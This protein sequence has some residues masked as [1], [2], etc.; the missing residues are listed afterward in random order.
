MNNRVLPILAGCVVVATVWRAAAAD[1]DDLS[2]TVPIYLEDSPAAQE[3]VDRAYHLRD[4][5]RLADAAAVMQQVIEQFPQKLM[6]VGGPRHED[7]ARWVRRVI[8]QDR[9]WLEA[10]RQTYEAEASRQL[11]MARAGGPNEAQ[12][13]ELSHRY[14]L[15][16]AGLEATLD[17]AGL[18]LERGAVEEATGLLHEAGEHPDVAEAGP[19]YAQLK[20]ASAVKRG[21][22]AAA[23][24]AAR[25]LE[26]SGDQPWT[27]VPWP[28]DAAV[29]PS[30]AAT[31]L[32]PETFA[33]PLWEVGLPESPTHDNVL[34]LRR[35]PRVSGQ[36]V[37]IN[38]GMSVLALDRASGRVLWTSEDVRG[39]LQQAQLG[40]FW[41]A[42]R[43]LPDERGVAV[44]GEHV[45]AVLG[46]DLQ[47]L[48]RR[49][50]WPSAAVLASVSAADGRVL[51]KAQPAE[52]DPTLDSAV[53]HGTPLLDSRRAYVLM[54][55]SQ[56]SGFHDAFV[57]AVDVATGKLAWRRHL[58]SAASG[59]R[60]AVR[61]LGS[62]LLEDG[63]LYITD[64]LGVVTCID[65]RTGAIVWSCLL[66]D[67][68]AA[69]GIALAW[70]RTAEQ[71]AS[72]PP[73]LVEAGLVVPA[74]TS[75]APTL[76]LDP[77]TGEVRRELTDEPWTSGGMLSEAGGD[78][79][80]SDRSVSCFD[81][82]TLAL[83][84]VHEAD[85]PPVTRPLA[86]GT[87]IIV[88]RRNR[89]VTLD[90]RTGRLLAD[91]RSPAATGLTVADEQV[92]L[93]T[94]SAVA[95]Y[96]PWDRAYARLTAAMR[97][98]P[99]DPAPGL[100]LAHVA[101]S[102]QR[103][104]A[105]I[106]GIDHAVATL[107]SRAAKAA[108]RPADTGG[109]FAQLLAFADGREVDDPL[110]R[111][112]VFNRL[113]AAAGTATEE[114]A[115]RMALAAFE[116]QTGQVAAAVDQYQS[117]LADDTL[118][119]QLHRDGGTVRQAWMQARHALTALV[120]EHGPQI[121]ER[122]EAAAALQFQQVMTA[123]GGDPA[124][125]QE[126]ARHYPLASV[127]A[128]ALWEAGRGLSEAGQLDDAIAVLR[129]AYR[130]APTPEAAARVVGG[131]AQ[132]AM[133]LDR[134]Q[135][136]RRWL[137][138]FSRMHPGIEPVFDGRAMSADAWLAS[139]AASPAASADAP[140]LQLPLR[141]ASFVPGRVLVGPD[142]AAG[143]GTDDFVVTQRGQTIQRHDGRDL[144][145]T[146]SAPLASDAGYEL[147]WADQ[148]Q[149]VV[150]SS[151]QSSLVALAA[152]SGTRLRDDLDTQSLLD[153]VDDGAVP[154]QEPSAQEGM[155][156]EM[157]DQPVFVRQGGVLRVMHPGD[158]ATTGPPR[159]AAGNEWYLVFADR[160]GRVAC[161]DRREGQVLWR[162]STSMQQI[163]GLR[164]RDDVLVVT[165]ITEPGTDAQGGLVAVLDAA[166]GEP[167]FT[168][169][170]LR[171]PLLMAEIDETRLLLATA[172]EVSAYHLSDGMVAWRTPV[173]GGGISSHGWILGDSL[174]LR[175]GGQTAG[176]LFIH[177]ATGQLQHRMP[178]GVIGSGEPLRVHTVSGL[179]YLI[180]PSLVGCVD[181]HGQLLWRDA[182]VPEGGR[183]EAA[184]V[185][186]GHVI[187]VARLGQ[188][189]A[190]EPG[191]RLQIRIGGAAGEVMVER[192]QADLARMVQDAQPDERADTPA[193]Y[194]VHVFD[195][196][197]GR[198][199]AHYTLGPIAALDPAAARLI[200]GCLVIAAGDRSL[201]IHGSE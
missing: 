3:L 11:A 189:G 57:A 97:D 53:F 153:S 173:E 77:S 176:L 139:V 180:A 68:V 85:D 40:R 9:A 73:V 197:G 38:S 146:W 41:H 88:P 140:A 138:M 168:P 120:A 54:R 198:M 6:K 87:S 66:A 185:T 110:W 12:L 37:L 67:A 170:E 134:P 116:A 69:D 50:L 155:L 175:E 193:S 28:G 108:D 200:D 129:R 152:D 135:V 36:T 14:L 33:A 72:D 84:W 151:A 158:A 95:S 63:R 43:L 27:A 89:L 186:A 79:L 46:P 16:R 25:A 148:E 141:E 34:L 59:H 119:R 61:P 45:V 105:M 18:A 159:M 137:A 10:Y 93:T 90:Q 150:W 91:L 17:L 35:V 26:Q 113:G 99:N 48:N 76:V 199:V 2:Q 163:T 1:P 122:Y 111:R 29:P 161:M 82:R 62:M 75:G 106:E 42:Q 171:E 124:R 184:W 65:V 192:L 83:R 123:Q 142:H 51:W 115:L 44:W 92:I 121:Y 143:V 60:F 187:A 182:A 183:Y 164:L 15:C 179:G 102:L 24:H 109:V 190:W 136:A 177:T 126:L 147:L 112:Q 107:R 178:R 19:R 117:V 194:L 56:M 86:V 131:L 39:E 55:R 78:V 20:L 100:A 8:A 104:D 181:P 191:G 32:L 166:T 31:M 201:V 22:A 130:Q 128:Q 47:R 160:Q 71:T 103:H 5:G 13:T 145:V 156:R 81:G 101:A 167:R 196:S 114:V 149:V 125:L 74:W 64:N 174:I 132:A 96:M 94:G 144:A 70:Q 80:V 127:S 118:S 58:S 4:Q 7:A 162:L 49:Q 188:A 172:T 165:G 133:R 98:Q 52:L 195:R 30:D 157:F 21:D 154:D 23:E 169:L